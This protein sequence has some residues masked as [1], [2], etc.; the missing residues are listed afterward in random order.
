MAKFK[1]KKKKVCVCEL[2]KVVLK[3]QLKTCK[4]MAVDT[5]FCICRFFQTVLGLQQITPHT[6]ISLLWQW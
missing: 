2:E 3:L 5:I 4:Q 6:H 1:K